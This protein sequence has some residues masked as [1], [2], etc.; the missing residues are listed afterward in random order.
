MACRGI[1]PAK[2]GGGS[3]YRE[4]GGGMGAALNAAQA[5][6]AY[7]ISDRGT[8]LSFANKGALTVLW[9]HRTSAPSIGARGQSGCPYARETQR[10]Q[11]LDQPVTKTSGRDVA[12][13]CRHR[14][15]T[16][17]E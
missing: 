11:Y 5:M 8:R 10:E 9:D 14:H 7:T 17:T 15:R 4:I 1:D 2:A 16:A 12:G 13:L 3:W 6:N